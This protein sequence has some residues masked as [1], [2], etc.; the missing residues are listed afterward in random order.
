MEKFHCLTL[1]MAIADHK[2]GKLTTYGLLDYYI[3]IKTS[4]RQVRKLPLSPKEVCTELDI[5][6][7]QFRRAIAKV[8][9]NPDLSSKINYVHIDQRSEQAPS[10]YGGV[11]SDDCFGSPSR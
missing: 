10:L 5:S 2:A 4:D 3:R 7:Q 9:A 8:R 6:M 11:I 1:P